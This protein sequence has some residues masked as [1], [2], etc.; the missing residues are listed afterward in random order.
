V[1]PIERFS[2]AGDPVRTA[3][4]PKTSVRR[5]PAKGPAFDEIEV[6]SAASEP[7]IDVTAFAPATTSNRA[8]F[9]AAPPPDDSR[10]VRALL[11]RA[12]PF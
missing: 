12:A 3:D 11:T 8:P 9:H 7:E 6:L 4:R 5:S 10:G 1:S 2:Q